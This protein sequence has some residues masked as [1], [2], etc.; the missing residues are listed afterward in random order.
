MKLIDRSVNIISNPLFPSLLLSPMIRS[1][2]YNKHRFGS[3][4]SLN[5]L[6]PHTSIVPWVYVLPFYFIWI[7]LLVV[8]LAILLY[9]IIPSLIKFTWRCF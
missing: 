9:T 3:T 7:T 2:S 8:L 6:P 5:I 1:T 4:T